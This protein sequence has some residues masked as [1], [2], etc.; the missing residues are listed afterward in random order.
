MAP[1]ITT[2]NGHMV[3]RDQ[4]NTWRWFDAFGLNVTKWVMDPYTLAL[5]TDATITNYTV[6]AAGTSPMTMVA[7]ADGGALL[8]TTG[9]S[10]NNGVQFQPVTEGFYFAQRWPCYFGAKF[11]IDD[12]DQSD[13]FLGL[14]ITDSSAATAVSDGIYFT[15]VDEATSLTFNAIKT[16]TGASTS[17]VVA[18]TL[19]DGGVFT[20]E[21]FFDGSTLTGYVNGSEV[22]SLDYTSAS[23]PND[24]YLTPIIAV[25]TGE[26]NAA[27]LT[28][29][30]AKAIQIRAAS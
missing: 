3:I 22:G 18:A 1:E 8:M 7:G 30:W 20:V 12:A 21:F 13:I 5:A 9:G 6:S 27:A 23:M 17:S 26:G 10:D 16:T 29:Y 14:S 24:E 28:L 25:L 15:S 11:S 2:I 19:T 4:I